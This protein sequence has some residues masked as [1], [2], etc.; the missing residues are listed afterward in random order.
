M[1]KK[2]CKICKHA[3]ADNKYGFIS[4]PFSLINSTADKF[5]AKIVSKFH[6]ANIP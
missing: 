1:N 5:T 2:A 4:Y 3:N 6:S